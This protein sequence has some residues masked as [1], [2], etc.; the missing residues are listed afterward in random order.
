MECF[1]LEFG[2]DHAG[3]GGIRPVPGGR[4]H[5]NFTIWRF[6]RSVDNCHGIRQ[7]GGVAGG[8]RECGAASR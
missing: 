8:F 6:G 3:F 7:K 2:V 4:L 5:G 1:R